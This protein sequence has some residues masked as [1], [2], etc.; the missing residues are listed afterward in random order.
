MTRIPCSLLVATVPFGSALAADAPKSNNVTVTL[1]YQHGLPYA[2]GKSIPGVLVAYGPGGY[3]PA[4]THPSS[5]LIYATVL[6]EAIRSHVNEGPVTTYNA[7]QSFSEL[8]GTRHRV[9]AHV[10]ETK[11]AK[12]LAVFVADTNETELTIPSGH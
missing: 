9:S 12:V 5:G 1:V 2:P 7:G 3:S 10:G 11:P 6:E 8:P 4:P